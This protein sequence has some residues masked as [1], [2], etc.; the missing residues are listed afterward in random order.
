MLRE[1]TAKT[2][3]GL[4]PPSEITQQRLEQLEQLADIFASIF[5][6]LT[7]EQRASYLSESQYQRA[8]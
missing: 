4:P 1:Y 5:A 8:A 2:V 6:R 3:A 7:S